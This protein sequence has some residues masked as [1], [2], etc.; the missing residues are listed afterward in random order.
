[1]KQING[2]LG[3]A[4]SWASVVRPVPTHLSSTAPHARHPA[5]PAGLLDRVYANSAVDM[6]E[7][8]VIGFDYDHTLVQYH[9]SRK[10][11][12][13]TASDIALKRLLSDAHA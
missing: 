13:G 11:F 2:L 5:K 9:K 8:D 4:G 6:A 10:A 3:D 1:M 12:Y 7:I